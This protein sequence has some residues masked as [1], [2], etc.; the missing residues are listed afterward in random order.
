MSSAILITKG[1]SPRE[2]LR[3]C[4]SKAQLCKRL[5]RVD[6]RQD[7]IDSIS[8]LRVG[9]HLTIS[10][11]KKKKMDTRTLPLH[12][13]SADGG[14]QLSEEQGDVVDGGNAIKGEQSER[15]KA[16]L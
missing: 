3:F 14:G 4:D 1:R 7:K 16:A 10:M 8:K 11:Q 13:P 5:R 12:R 9:L 6:T 15:R 2:N